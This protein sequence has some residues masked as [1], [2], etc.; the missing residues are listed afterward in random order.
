[1]TCSQMG[2]MC[3]QNVHGAT[4]Q[5]MIKNGMVHLEEAHP[6]MAATIKATSMDDPMMKEWSEKFH[7]DFEATPEDAE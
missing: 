6:E 1:M 7:R 2:G 4:E 5:E 3:G